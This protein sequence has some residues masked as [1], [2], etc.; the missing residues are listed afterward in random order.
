MAKKGLVRYL[1]C[2]YLKKADATKMKLYELIE[3]TTFSFSQDEQH[4]GAVQK[5]FQERVNNLRFLL[6]LRS[7]DKDLEPEIFILS[8]CFLDA[9]ASIF[10][11]NSPGVRFRRILYDF[12]GFRDVDFNMVSLTELEKI[13]RTDKS[14]LNGY[15]LDCVTKKIESIDYA[16]IS[17]SFKYDPLRNILLEELL[18]AKEGKLNVLKDAVENA[19]YASVLYNK[20]RNPAIHEG[21]P[22]N[23]WNIADENCIYYMRILG[24]RADLVFPAKFLVDLVGHIFQ[25]VYDKIEE[26]L[27]A[28]RVDKECQKNASLDL[29]NLESI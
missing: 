29:G 24:S 15:C 28:D 3:K 26:G 20:Y 13:L 22:K 9:F 25:N 12:G 14:G 6:S 1:N 5:H 16:Q 21:I 10:Y 27:F 11:N 7:K 18:K 19:T 17:E 8:C 4:L 2:Y 23:H